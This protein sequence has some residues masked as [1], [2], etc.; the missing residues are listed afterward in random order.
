MQ[1]GRRPWGQVKKSHGGVKYGRAGRR[2]LRVEWRRAFP[3]ARVLGL[4]TCGWEGSTEKESVKMGK[5][6]WPPELK[7]LAH[8][9]V[10]PLRLEWPFSTFLSLL[11]TQT[12][13]DALDSLRQPPL[14]HLASASCLSVPPG[15]ML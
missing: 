4:L 9:F 8:V 2:M 10:W 5:R 7:G 14:I 13:E 3:Q 12:V 11:C 15:H 6:G 1:T